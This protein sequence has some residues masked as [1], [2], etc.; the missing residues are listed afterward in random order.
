M[1]FLIGLLVY[2]VLCLVGW[3]KVA[4]ERPTCPKH[5]TDH[6]CVNRWRC[7]QCAIIAEQRGLRKLARERN[8]ETYHARKK[9]VV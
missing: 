1:T 7:R 8:V 9:G 2:L 3:V 5:G 4:M 6:Y